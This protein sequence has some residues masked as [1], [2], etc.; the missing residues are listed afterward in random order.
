LL[1]N[2]GY[3]H[4]LGRKHPAALG[5]PFLG[6]WQEIRAELTP[7]VDQALGGES[8]H[9]DDIQLTLERNGDPEEAHFAFSYTPVRDE[10][11]AVAGLFCPCQEITQQVLADRRAK[12]ERDR[13]GEL[14]Q[15]APGFM[16]MLRGPEH[17]FELVNAAYM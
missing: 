12:A 11:G 5:R 10:S 14:F 13:L 17:V 6:V 16:A 2:D 1:Y 4:I 7:L 8:V 3:A 15:Q 9:M